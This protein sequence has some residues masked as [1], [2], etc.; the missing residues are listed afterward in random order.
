MIDPL[1]AVL[2]SGLGVLAF[3]LVL[4]LPGFRLAERLA[5][6]GRS[7]LARL[8]LALLI[9]QLTVVAIGSVLVAV[10]GFSGTAVALIALGLGVLSAPAALRWLRDARSAL[11]TVGW[12]GVLVLPWIAFVGAAG[13]PPADTLQWYYAGLASQLNQ[14]G[15]VPG[16]VAEWGE[17]VRWLPDYLAFDIP[18]EVFR[19]L[20]PFVTP[21]DAIDAWRVPIAIFGVLLV[22]G[23]LRLWL[24]RAPA[25]LGTVLVVG[26]TFYLAKFNAYKP[27]AFGIV[28]GLAALSL[29]V[30]GLRGGH[31]SWVLLAGATLGVALSVHAIAATAMGLVVAGFGSAEL[32]ALHTDR[33]SRFGWLIRAAL[34]G[35]LISVA[36][37]VGLQGRAVAATGALNPTA[38][39]G[40]DPTWTFFLRST[41]QFAEP[42][43]APPA[44][45]LA[46]GVTTPWAGFRV[47][48]AF[49]WWL[50][51]VVAIG[52]YFLVAFGGRRA[53]AGVAGLVVSTL[54]LGVTI[55]FFALAFDTYV[56]RWTGLV[57]FGQYVPLLVAIATAMAVD[58][59]L[60]AWARMAD[61]RIP[62]V[63]VLVT[64]IVG[65]VWL[66]PI[67]WST[68]QVQPRLAPDGIAALDALR[69]HAAP[70][71]IVLSNALTTGTIEFFAPVEVP[72]EGRQPLIEEPGFLATANALLLDAHRWFTQ[73]ADRAFVDRLGARWILVT[74]DPATL[75]AT[76]GLG[77]GTA[78]LRG[79]DGLREVWAGHG[80]ALLEVAA[81][82]TPPASP[83]PTDD[84]T[85]IVN[86]PRSVGAAGLLVVVGGLLVAPLDRLRRRRRLPEG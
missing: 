35:L 67:A 46:G 73:P 80:I 23:A 28:L 77:G 45:P 69:S 5:G 82:S 68:Y 37:G 70:N 76:A 71:D 64:A 9:S 61:A 57:R 44:R 34:L 26:G 66:V 48:S 8:V 74:D 31:R 79:L 42:P 20:L 86:L 4:V 36:M 19:A 1:Q 81:P 25:V 53:R 7:V 84:L 32:V 62:R 47:T 29:L 2:L 15:G 30:R 65:T 52:L 83:A 63:L 6:P 22:F 50:I 18:S 12:T 43:P 59:Y 39:A 58:G 40:E 60:R 75:G 13:W 21:A 17:R 55:G 56:P 51:P 72:L 11:A 27:E 49:G 38:V 78:A 54:L 24:A 3:A 16:S 14:A 85:P 41:G 10:G 33:R